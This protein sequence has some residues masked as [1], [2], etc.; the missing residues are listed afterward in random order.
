MKT[1]ENNY[2]TDSQKILSYQQA[3]GGEFWATAD[4]NLLKGAPFTTIESPVYLLDLGMSKDDSIMLKCQEKIFNTWMEDGRFRLIPKGTIYPCQTVRALNT[5]CKMGAT[6]DE[7]LQRTFDYLIDTQEADGGWKCQKYSFG[8]G[9]ETNYSTPMTT[10]IALDCFR[11]LDTKAYEQKLN[12]AVEFLLQHWDIKRPI[13]PCHHG[14]GTLFMQGEYPFRSYNLFYYL[15]VL[16]F[17]SYAHK[18]LRF[19]NALEELKQKIQ[20]GQ[21]IV[22]RVV[23]KLAK[24]DFC[25]KGKKSA[26]ATKRYNELLKN[27][28]VG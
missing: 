19:L 24:L 22:E 16:S 5:L 1:V 3:N 25:E 11:H 2:E 6:S 18:D 27:L 15:Y 10:L 23:P 9:A 8:R 28:G 4:G 14:I 12:N 21:V 13:G 17:Y 7:R 26:L 20:D